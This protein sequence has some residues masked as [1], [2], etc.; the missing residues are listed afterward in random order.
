VKSTSG[1]C[2]G[3]V[4]DIELL[5]SGVIGFHGLGGAQDARIAQDGA[6]P[7]AVSSTH[8]RN[9]VG[10]NTARQAVV[11]FFSRLSLLNWGRIGSPIPLCRRTSCRS[12]RACLE[13]DRKVAAGLNSQ[14]MRM[15][16][17]PDRRTDGKEAFSLCPGLFWA[18]G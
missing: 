11:T 12:A 3:R 5:L 1:M 14:G 15:S 2:E 18:G 6:L 8:C 17:G 10:L 4:A 9:L 13:W 7:A 16:P